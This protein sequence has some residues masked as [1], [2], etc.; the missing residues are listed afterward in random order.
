MRA[1]GWR[2]ARRRVRR[3]PAHRRVRKG[4]IAA[5]VIV[6]VVSL[7][8]R[9]ARPP[10]VRLVRHGGGRAPLLPRPVEVGAGPAGPPAPVD[11]APARGGR[12]MRRVAPDLAFVAV[13]AVV[14]VWRFVI[15]S[16]AGAPPGVDSGNWLALGHDLAGARL[17]STTIVYPPLV[18][19]V[20]AGAVDSLGLVNGVCAVVVAASLLGG[21]AVHV[22]LRRCGLRWVAAALG[23]LV[24]AGSATGEAAAW[25]GIPQLTSLGLVVVLLWAFDRFLRGHRLGHAALTGVMMAG[26]LATSHLVAFAAVLCAGVLVAVHAAVGRPWRTAGF[27]RLLVGGALVLAPCAPLAPLYLDMVGGLDTAPASDEGLVLVGPEN[28]LSSVD[29][30]FRDF[31]V[32][33]RLALTAAL[34]MPFMLRHRRNLATWSI[35]TSLLVGT[36]LATVLTRQTRFLY[37]LPV[38]TVLAL[39]VWAQEAS[40]RWRSTPRRVRMA[41]AGAAAVV[42]VQLA[43]GINFFTLQRDYYAV[44]DRDL[45][46]GIDWV[47][48]STPPGAS[49]AVTTGRNDHLLGWWV[50]GLSE[51]RTLFASRL[52]W[53]N[54][55]DERQRARTANALFAKG[56][57]G[58]P[59]LAS[60]RREGIDYVLIAKSWPGYDD[61]GLADFRNGDP[62]G[63]AYENDSVVV[64]RLG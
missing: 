54:Y 62:R 19:Q 8:A 20:V 28:L 53:L 31:A 49:V 1:A 25:G 14:A 6:L 29:F 2:H 56:F 55:D 3:V 60:A 47:R 57:P 50:E 34:A 41:S 32:L 39:A 52:V 13:C 7:V 18:P 38:A 51:R 61:G 26:L 10:A 40:T 64:L 4:G 46:A 59:A 15:L 24:V 23:V 22:V 16:G 63:V 21:A 11:P 37:L 30:L 17:R 48:T 36:G 9:G 33:W 43:L 44:L 58:T 42:A 27:R 45:V 5:A 12:S 35:A